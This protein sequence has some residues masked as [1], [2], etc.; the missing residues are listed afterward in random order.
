[1]IV[2]IVRKQQLPKR[3]I[4]PTRDIDILGNYRCRG[5]DRLILHDARNSFP[6]TP[7]IGFKRKC[8]VS[9]N[10]KYLVN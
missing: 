10:C 2:S 6:G 4:G 5:S 9:R 8:S 3:K 7:W 1:M